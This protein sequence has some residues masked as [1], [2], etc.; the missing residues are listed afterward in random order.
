MMFRQ[1]FLQN[2]DLFIEADVRYYIQDP[3]FLEHKHSQTADS[4]GGQFKE[5]LF[6]KAILVV[7]I[8]RLVLIYF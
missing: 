7:E 4:T 6:Y 1:L 3:S 5:D 8:K 2:C